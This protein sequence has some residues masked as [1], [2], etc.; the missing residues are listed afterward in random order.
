M[1]LIISD[2]LLA[3]FVGRPISGHHCPIGA[4]AHERPSGSRRHGGAD[5]LTCQVPPPV[6]I[7]YSGICSAMPDTCWFTGMPMLMNCCGDEVRQ[8]VRVP[9]GRLRIRV[10]QWCRIEVYECMR[11]VTLG[12]T[13]GSRPTWNETRLRGG[14]PWKDGGLNSLDARWLTTTL[15]LAAGEPYELD[16]HI[17]DPAH[18]ILRRR[19]VGPDV[20]VVDVEAIR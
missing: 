17:D 2:P 1:M 14:Q 7:R 5:L 9:H 4:M 18:L 20:V 15:R 16:L 12:T 13:P 6:T 19:D 3:R 11:L 8:I 10:S